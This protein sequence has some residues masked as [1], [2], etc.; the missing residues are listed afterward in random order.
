MNIYTNRVPFQLLNKEEQ[1]QLRAHRGP[2]VMYRHNRN[3]WE[4]QYAWFMNSNTTAQGIYRAIP[5]WIPWNAIKEEVLYVSYC[6]SQGF[7]GHKSC[8]AP[9]GNEWWSG[10]EYSLDALK[11]KSYVELALVTRK[12]TVY[13]NGVWV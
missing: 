6:D 12:E 9:I 1:D 11:V 7:L 4:T 2:M 13:V 8:P 10:C 3:R 5:L